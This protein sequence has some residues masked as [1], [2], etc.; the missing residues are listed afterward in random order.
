MYEEVFGRSPEEIVDAV[1]G[2][3]VQKDR[4]RMRSNIRGTGEGPIVGSSDHE[5]GDRE[6]ESTFLWCDSSAKRDDN[7]VRLQN[8]TG[9]VL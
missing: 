6:M 7:G 3:S 5:T 8:L 1:R 2:R 9:K 4:K